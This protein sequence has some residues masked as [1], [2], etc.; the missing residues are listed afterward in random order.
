MGNQSFSSKQKQLQN[1][2]HTCHKLIKMCDGD[3]SLST[4]S[5]STQSNG[6]PNVHIATY[7]TQKCVHPAIFC[8]G[9][10][11]YK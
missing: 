10:S 5:T 11:F 7:Q 4:S 1:L 2:R 8:Q 3:V 6:A 9:G